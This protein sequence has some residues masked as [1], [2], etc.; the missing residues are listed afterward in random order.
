MEDFLME[1]KY[2]SI[3]Q[4]LRYYGILKELIKLIVIP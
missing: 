1:S 3:I 4:K 2:R